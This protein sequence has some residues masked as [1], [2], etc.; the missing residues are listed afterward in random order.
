MLWEVMSSGIISLMTNRECDITSTC[1]I[2]TLLLVGD[3][4]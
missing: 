1:I 2:V 4:A 3:T